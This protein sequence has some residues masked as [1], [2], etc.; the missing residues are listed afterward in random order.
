MCGV[1]LRLA[2]IWQKDPGSNLVSAD[3]RDAWLKAD[4]SEGWAVGQRGEILRFD[5]NEK[6]GP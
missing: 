2:G 6:G 4:G 5:V 1:I 3:L